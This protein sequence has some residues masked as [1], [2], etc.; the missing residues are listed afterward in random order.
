MRVV[1]IF[2]WILSVEYCEEE[3]VAVPAALSLVLT[4]SGIQSKW[5][6]AWIK[7]SRGFYLKWKV[8]AVRGGSTEKDGGSDTEG[9]V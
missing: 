3:N 6:A 8:S 5:S 2:R 1:G 4:D 9:R 7:I